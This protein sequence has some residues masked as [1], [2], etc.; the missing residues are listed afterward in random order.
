[1]STNIIIM[2]LLAVLASIM[3]RDRLCR[4]SGQ[5][6]PTD[7]DLAAAEFA[8]AAMSKEDMFEE[9]DPTVP[10]SLAW[11]MADSDPTNVGSTAWRMADADPTNIGS[12]AWLEAQA[13]HDHS[14]EHDDWVH[15][16]HDQEWPHHH[17]H[18]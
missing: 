12:T 15:H 14:H 4:S 8:A 17:D 18:D 2:A 3:V 5:A 7:P 1:M 11:L 10:G 16:H 13:L 9:S 6:L